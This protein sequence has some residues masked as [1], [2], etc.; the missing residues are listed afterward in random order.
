M[1]EDIQR[2]KRAQSL[3]RSADSLFRIRGIRPGLASSVAF[4]VETFAPNDFA[5]QM[6]LRRIQRHMGRETLADII[7]YHRYSI[8]RW[9]RGLVS[10]Q[11]VVMGDWANG[12]GYDLALGLVPH[13]RPPQAV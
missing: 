12:L 9:E 11:L 5:Q 4:E 6:A 7:G 10:P 1:S 2:M 8:E 13:G 3:G